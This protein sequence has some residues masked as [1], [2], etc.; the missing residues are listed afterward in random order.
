[1]SRAHLVL[2]GALT[3]Y[4]AFNAG[5]F[6][7]GSVALVAIVLALALVLRITIAARPLAGWSLGAAAAAGA[8]A[9]LSCWTLLSGLW[10]DVPSAALI[11]FDR[12]LVY[13]LEFALMATF[14]RRPGDLSVL[15]RWVAVAIAAAAVA[16]LA[17]RLYPDV[18]E[19]VAGRNPARLA[20]PLTY[21]NAMAVLCALGAVLA[22][23]LASGRGE[24]AAVRVLATASL[25]LLCVTGYFSFSRGAIAT[26]VIGL[27]AYAVLAHPRRLL[28]TIASAGPAVV[29]ALMA[30]YGAEALATDAYF[31]GEG[32]EEGR[33][34]ARVLAAT[35]AGAGLLRLLLLLVERRVTRVQL[36]PARRRAVLAAVAALAVAVAAVA[37]VAF[38]APERARA[39]YRGFVNANLVQESA[40]TR[41]RLGQVSNNG[42]IDLWEVDLQAFRSDRLRGVGA[43][44]FQF[45]W[46]REREYPAKSVDGH[47]L[48]LETLAELGY[49]GLALLGVALAVILLTLARNLRG[50]ERHAHAAVL[51][52]GGALLVHAGL[53]WDWEM[54]ALFLWLFG[55]AGVAAA[56]SEGGRRGGGPP[57]LA[58]VV[59]GLLCLGL[60]VTPVLIARSQHALD[61]GV[62]AF[63]R[64]DCAGAVDGA[65]DSLAALRSRPEPYE[66]LAYCDLR[67]GEERL[68]VRAM[69]AARARNPRDW[70]YAYGLA[71]AQALAGQDPRPAIATARRLSP[72]E[73]LARELAHALQT[74]RPARWRRA[75]A[76]TAIPTE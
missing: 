39:Q 3:V 20:Y 29:I 68:A 46:E 4:F 76:A 49:V 10:S 14:P 55:A 40:D 1:M 13:L 65:L 24:P 5:G 16:G 70:R 60:A 34:V 42:R 51:A 12:L 52:A 30:A 58:R 61:R 72:R 45:E 26:A 53:D 38:D 47:S 7:P 66:L 9:L 8:L 54:P 35:M 62:D 50:P 67:G 21:W 23:H 44:T 28:F 17:T 33:R 31:R 75:A 41:Q 63:A 27:V 18:F 64:G 43:G 15:L 32:P 6:F 25:P 56:R 36:A 2:P 74:D 11:E 22:A 48:Y 69:S 37:A 71:V 73:R 19:A 59:A 57:R